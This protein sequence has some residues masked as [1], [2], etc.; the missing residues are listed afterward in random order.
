MA[1]GRTVATVIAVAALGLL[2]AAGPAAG[3]LVAGGSGSR[4]RDCVTVFDAPGANTPPPPRTPTRIDCVDG[5]PSCDAD[6]A[7]NARCLFTL[8]LCVN[9]TAFPGCTPERAD[10][11]VIDHALDNG[12]PRFDTEFQALQ[13]RANLL[14]FPDDEVLDHCTLQSSV[15]LALVPPPG[16][17]GAWGMSKKRLR[18]T[19]RGRAGGRVTV[20]RDRLSFA[21]R[22]EGNGIYSPRDLYTGTF[23]RIA[24]EIFAPRCAVPACHDSQSHQ[25]NQILLPNAAYSQIV[26]VTPTTGAAAADGLERIFPGD[27]TRSFLYRKITFDLP[28]GYGSGMPLTGPPLSPAQAEIIRLWILGDGILGPAP[29]TGWV[30]GTDG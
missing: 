11:V 21:C 19:T 5:D 28:A 13:S 6:G 3:V 17:S 16:A 9:S 18:V 7:R 15:S 4:A 27:P 25:A 20:D 8:R 1:W 23:D 12:D 22:P 2:A 10:G 30:P 26:G 29:Q 24:Q 14:G